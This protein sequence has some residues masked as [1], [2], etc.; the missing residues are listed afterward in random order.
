MAQEKKSSDNLIWLDMEMTGLNPDRDRV[1]ELAGDKHQPAVGADD[2]RR[3]TVQAIDAG[4]AVAMESDE[5]QCAG[6]RIA[7]PYR[8]GVSPR[9]VV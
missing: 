5:A 7:L 8:Q 9:P 3:G 4:D 1:I 6:D 2:H